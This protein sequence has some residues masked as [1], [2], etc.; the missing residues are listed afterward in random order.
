MKF[1]RLV[2]DLNISERWHLGNLHNKENPKIDY[3]LYSKPYIDQFPKGQLKIELRRNGMPLDFCFADYN[4]IIISKRFRD[5]LLT[6]YKGLINMMPV[7]I[8]ANIDKNYFLMNIYHTVDCI[9]EEESLFKKY[10]K[11]DKARPDLAGQYKVVYKLVI[12][13]TKVQKKAIFRIKNYEV[14]IVVTQEFKKMVKDYNIT[15]CTF[16]KLAVNE[17]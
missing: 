1:F 4:T 11:D 6:K 2:E 3:W 16:Q 14:Q 15:G 7:E 13:P 5:L 12:N 10:S 8:C 17:N 9:D